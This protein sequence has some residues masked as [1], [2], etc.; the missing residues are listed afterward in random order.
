MKVLREVT[1]DL[2]KQ[3]GRSVPNFDPD[4][5]GIEAEMLF[6]LQDPEPTVED[7]DFI[8]RDNYLFNRRDGSARNIAR[9]RYDVDLDRERMIPWNAIRGRHLRRT[10]IRNAKR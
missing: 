7:T 10:W 8:S 2:R 3:T 5:G 9:A 4:D 6:V 1:E